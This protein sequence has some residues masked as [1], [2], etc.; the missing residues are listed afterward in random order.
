[1]LNPLHM[2][3]YLEYAGIDIKPLIDASAI[4]KEYLRQIYRVDSR[5]KVLDREGKVIG[6]PKCPRCLH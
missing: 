6:K 5:E 2:L 3:E 4:E 1:M